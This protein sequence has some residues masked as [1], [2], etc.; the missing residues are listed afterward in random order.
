MGA[1]KLLQGRFTPQ[2]SS[3]YKG[4][5]TN[6]IYRSGWE[7]RFMKWCDQTTAVL[8]WGS[9]EVVVPYVS[10]WDGHIHRYFI[11]FAIKIRDKTGSLKRYL[12]EI[13]PLRYTI[14]PKEPK[15]KTARYVQ[16]VKDYAVNQ[17]KWTAAKELAEE[18]GA[19]FLVLTERDLGLDS[20]SP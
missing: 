5:P 3:K 9:E 13:K 15:R 17:A 16:E 2:N 8:E 19:E 14:P 20:K 1:T 7:M 10:P 4:D 18:T 6:I 11:D 12:I